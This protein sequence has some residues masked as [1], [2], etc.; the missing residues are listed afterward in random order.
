MVT[1]LLLRTPDVPVFS[2]V[3]GLE[4]GP[5]VVW[6]AGWSLYDVGRE[7][8]GAPLWLGVVPVLDTAAAPVFSTRN[9]EPLLIL[10][11]GQLVIRVWGPRDAPK[12]L[13]DTA[14]N[15]FSAGAPS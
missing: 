15:I 8:D 2:P 14:A 11:R 5:V 6:A 9:F 13:L 7:L 10:K 12:L 1:L 4:P 3:P